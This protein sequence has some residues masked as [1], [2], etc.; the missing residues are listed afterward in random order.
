MQHGRS[1]P[2]GLGRAASVVMA[3]VGMLSL[4]VAALGVLQ[5]HADVYLAQAVVY[6]VLPLIVAAAAAALLRAKVELRV[7]VALAMVATGLALLVAEVAASAWLGLSARAH[8]RLSLRAQ[9]MQLRATGV[10]AFPRIPGNVIVD[11]DPQFVIAGAV[12]HPISPGPGHTTILLCDE[13]R[14]LLTYQG[15]RFGLDNPD[16]LWEADSVPLAIVGDSYTVGVC[17]P[18]A[19]A[20]PGRLRAR[21]A[22]LNLGISGAGPMHELALLRELA[23]P[24]H[25]RTVVWVFFE[26]NDFY[27]IGREAAR[28]WL[29]AYL[30]PEHSQQI[31]AHRAQM[32]SAFRRWSD[33]LTA[34]E[35][36]AQAPPPLW[37]LG[38]VLKLR[39]IR[40]TVPASITRPKRDSRVE[41]LRA[42]L[43]RARG[44]VEGWGGR[45]LVVYMPA[46]RRYGV[47]VG[48]PYPLRPAVLRTIRE[49]DL[50][51]LDLDE[52]FRATGN[53]RAL[54]VTPRSHLTP[55]G[56]AI[57]ARAI[58]TALDLRTSNRP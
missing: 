56:Y 42:V 49:L 23:A 22:L 41:L 31:V 44:D 51:L 47:R 7:G 50:E 12:K 58:E 32:D 16:S 5:W 9:L 20:I 2:L 11:A 4:A 38:D 33:S 34:A 40:R 37:R 15:D 45:F 8:Q 52:A 24:K 36:E 21:G 46:Y 29:R 43:A 39:A 14:P 18:A 35:P 27:D 1:L 28:D 10:D 13:D 25:P 54:W 48:E 26:G 30:D 57:A 3:L 55:E 6:V 53:P 17:V 19:D